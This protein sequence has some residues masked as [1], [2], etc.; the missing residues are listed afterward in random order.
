MPTK[1]SCICSEHFAE[2]EILITKKGY[3]YLDLKVVPTKK[4]MSYEVSIHSHNHI[5]I[6]ADVTGTFSYLYESVE[7]VVN[8]YS[9]PR[10]YSKPGTSGGG[11][12]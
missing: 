6:E 1:S 8:T 3:R 7:N 11:L 9:M 2:N 5:V 10:T 12:A 4:I